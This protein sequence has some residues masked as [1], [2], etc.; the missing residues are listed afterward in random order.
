MKT[1]FYVWIMGTM[2]LIATAPEWVGWWWAKMDDTYW[3]NETWSD[4]TGEL[5]NCVD[6]CPTPID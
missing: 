1:I 6:D 3:A 2:T 4:M 5:V